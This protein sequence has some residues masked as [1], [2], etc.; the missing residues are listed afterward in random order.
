MSVRDRVNRGKNIIEVLEL[1]RCRL[2]STKVLSMS[3]KI[4]VRASSQGTEGNDATVTSRS[5]TS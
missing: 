4:E 1:G 3:P 5:M 2:G